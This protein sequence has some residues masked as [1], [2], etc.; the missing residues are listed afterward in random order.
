MAPKLDLTC[1]GAHVTISERKEGADKR[2]GGEIL[3]RVHT[4][5]EL[6]A[7]VFEELDPGAR[8]TSCSTT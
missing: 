4:D 3:D 1:I 2:E 5:P 7:D 8:P 6:E